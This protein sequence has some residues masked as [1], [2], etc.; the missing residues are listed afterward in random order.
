MSLVCCNSEETGEDSQSCP[1]N[2]PRST[3]QTD[4]RRREP[5][6]AQVVVYTYDQT[7]WPTLPP[8]ALGEVYRRPKLRQPNVE[9]M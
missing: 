9:S 8:L 6:I 2:A 5:W 4:E 1:E 3:G 7:T